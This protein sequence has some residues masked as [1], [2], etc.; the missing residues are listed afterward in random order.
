MEFIAHG[1][2]RAVY[3][4]EHRILSVYI[5][6]AVNI[7]FFDNYERVVGPVRETIDAPTWA[8]MIIVKGPGVIPEGSLVKIKETLRG[9]TQKGLIVSAYVYGEVEAPHLFKEHILSQHTDSGVNIEFFEDIESAK[10][11][12]IDYLVGK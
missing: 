12:L 1:D 2:V 5:D 11:W 8:S 9:S 4:S 3:D 7:E 10:A 6:G